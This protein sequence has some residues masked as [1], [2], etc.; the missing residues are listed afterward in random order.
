M[1]INSLPSL[2]HFSKW[3]RISRFLCIS[4]LRRSTLVNCLINVFGEV[5][6]ME[7][8][9]CGYCQFIV[10]LN[11]TT[12]HSPSTLISCNFDILRAM[13]SSLSTGATYNRCWFIC[14]RHVRFTVPFGSVPRWCSTRCSNLLHNWVSTGLFNISGHAN[15]QRS[16]IQ[17]STVTLISTV[18]LQMF[19]AVLSNHNQWSI[20]FELY[21]IWSL[22]ISNP[23]FWW[24]HEITK[25][26]WIECR[27]WKLKPSYLF[28]LFVM[29]L[30]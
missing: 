24:Q 15:F 6:E 18:N 1:S 27:S 2:E 4:L 29:S 26:R 28:I 20:H 14:G 12:C 7:P 17:L 22:D 23:R 30:S 8:K 3:R 16:K 10:S 25:W 19:S 11:S 9:K 13:P 21:V 5:K